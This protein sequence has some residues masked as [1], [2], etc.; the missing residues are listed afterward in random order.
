MLSWWWGGSGTRERGLQAGDRGKLA[1]KT[2][3]AF[4]VL[5]ILRS[6]SNLFEGCQRKKNQHPEKAGEKGKK[7][8]IMSCIC[9]EAMCVPR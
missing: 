8:N 6:A 9:V 3:K 5:F 2:T 4:A 1:R 7:N